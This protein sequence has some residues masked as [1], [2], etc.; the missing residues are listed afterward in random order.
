MSAEATNES[1]PVAPLLGLRFERLVRLE[2][3]RDDECERC[4]GDGMDPWNDCMLP[5]P[6]CGGRDAP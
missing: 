2:P 6:A 3:E 4:H 5:C 1:Q